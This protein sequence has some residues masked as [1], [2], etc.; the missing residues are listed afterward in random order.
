MYIRFEQKR[1]NITFSDLLA[2]I[3]AS[4]SFTHTCVHRCDTLIKM[5]SNSASRARLVASPL[6]RGGILVLRRSAASAPP[7]DHFRGLPEPVK[8]AAQNIAGKLQEHNIPYC[9]AGAVACNVHG[10][11][12]A[13]MD[14]DVLVNNNNLA[15]VREALTG[16]GYAPRFAGSRRSFRDTETNVNIDILISGEYP[17]DGMP[18]PVQFPRVG[19]SA[20]EQCETEVVEGIAVLSLPTLIQLKLASSSAPGRQKDAADVLALIEAN[21]LPR[22]FANELDPSVRERFVELWTDVQRARK[23]GLQ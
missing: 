16:R 3:R 7:R 17:G 6:L 18:K 23:A 14:V 2:R 22:E 9:I 1:G 19:R 13:T 10:H 4:Q 12:R 8:K 15:D 20:E 11:Q 5:L 21:D